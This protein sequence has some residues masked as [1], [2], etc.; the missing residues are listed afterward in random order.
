MKPWNIFIILCLYS[1][2]CL[3]CSNIFSNLI[4]ISSLLGGKKCFHLLIL[5]LNNKNNSPFKFKIFSA[6]VSDII[7][8]PSSSL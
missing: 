7:L 2:Y 8:S 4:I 6:F 3:S 1:L 5:I